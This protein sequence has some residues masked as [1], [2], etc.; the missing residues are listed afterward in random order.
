MIR[1]SYNI[2]ITMIIKFNNLLIISMNELTIFVIR[3][4]KRIKQLSPFSFNYI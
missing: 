3:Q 4:K 2:V 1:I